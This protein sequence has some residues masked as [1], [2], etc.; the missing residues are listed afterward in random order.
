[1]T[2]KSQV[3]S[4]VPDSHENIACILSDMLRCGVYIVMAGGDDIY[5]WIS[6]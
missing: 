3:L 4:Y 5:L 1:M 2:M 6:F